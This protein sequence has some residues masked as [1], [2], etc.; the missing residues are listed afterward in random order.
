MGEQA[1]QYLSEERK[2]LEK[3]EEAPEGFSQTKSK[4]RVPESELCQVCRKRVYPMES[5]IAD[6]QNFHKSCFRCAHCSSQL[7]LGNY[8]SLRGRMYCKPHYKQLFKSK[9][10]YDEGFGERPHKELWTPGVQDKL[11]K[12][13][14]N[15][16]FCF[17]CNH[18]IQNSCIF[19]CVCFPCLQVSFTFFLEHS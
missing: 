15:I 16:C 3:Q 10:N 5:L 8:A 11:G 17:C 9:G 2:N 19:A 18:L 1:H 7:S 14:N 4:I 13:D 12:Y 6:K